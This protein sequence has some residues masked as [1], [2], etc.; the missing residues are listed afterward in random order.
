[1][2]LGTVLSVPAVW[3][4]L[5][6]YTL[7]VCADAAVVGGSVSLRRSMHAL[8]HLKDCKDQTVPGCVHLAV[9]RGC[10]GGSE[11]CVNVT[12]TVLADN[13]PR[14]TA[15]CSINLHYIYGVTTLQTP[16]AESTVTV[17]F[18]SLRLFCISLSYTY[19]V[20][21]HSFHLMDMSHCQHYSKNLKPFRQCQPHPCISVDCETQKK[22]SSVFLLCSF[23][24]VDSLWPFSCH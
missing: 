23:S 1:M 3:L 21:C 4:A 7:A 13:V 6:R 8:W 22:L 19:P 9:S 11:Q 17:A 16:W 18:E 10:P 14:I 5:H 2:L 24:Q 20:G 15:A 12:C